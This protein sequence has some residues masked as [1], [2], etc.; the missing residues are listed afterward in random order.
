MRLA[1]VIILFGLILFLGA[2]IY[3]FVGLEQEAQKT[4]SEYQ[5]KL[6]KAKFDEQKFQDELNYYSSQANIE[7]ELRKRFNYRAPGE[8]LIIIVPKNQSSTGNPP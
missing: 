1:A 5:A 4:F 6:D 7:K 8:K 3:T 2:Q